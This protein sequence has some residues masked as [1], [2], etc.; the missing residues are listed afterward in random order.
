MR[1]VSVDF[2]SFY[3]SSKEDDACS[4]RTMGGRK[5]CMDPRT[6]PYLISVSDGTETWAGHPRDFNFDSLNGQTLLSHNQG[7]DGLMAKEKILSGVM[8]KFTPAAWHCTANLSVYLSMR[9][10]LLRAAEFLLGVV[11]DKSYRLDADG[12]TGEQLM[13]DP[14]V[15]EKVMAAGR[16]DA[17][18]CW[19]LWAKYSHLWPEHERRLSE[20]TIRQGHRGVQ[21]DVDLL[22]K[23]LHAG[24]SMAINAEQNL[25]WIAEGGKPR[26]TKALAEYCRKAGIPMAPVKKWEGEDAYDEWANNYGAKYPWVKAFS[27]YATINKFIKNCETF[28]ERLDAENVLS[29]DLL[30]FGAH[31]GRWAGGG[32][33]NF[34]A[35]RKTPLFCDHDLFLITD[36]AKQKEIE[37][38][39]SAQEEAKVPLAERTPP[40]F[41]A[42]VLDIRRLIIP[43]PGCKLIS[44]DLS[45]IEPR[46]EAWIVG[47]TK[48]LANMAAGK[49]P[50]QA[51]AEAY[52]DWPAE[53]DLKKSDKDLYAL[54]K[55]RILG[56]GFQCGWKKFITVAM[57]MAQLD[58]TKND[59][60][61]IQKLD[62]DGNPMFKLDGNPMMESG[63]GFTSKK[64]VKE[65]RES[66]PLIASNDETNPGI[67]RRL[68][69]L[70]RA[71]AGGDFKMTLPSGRDLRYPEVKRLMRMKQDEETGKMQR[72]WETTA[73][74]FDPKRNGV[75]RK[76]FYGGILTE[77]LVQ[78]T[79]RDI[80][81]E[82]LLALDAT[83]G[84]EVLF[85]VHDE[86]VCEVAEH[87]T[88]HDV[89]TIMG[90]TPEW[91]AGCPIAAEANE[92]PFYTK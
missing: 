20:L 26:S 50:Y 10:D 55:A 77:N 16:S 23:F 27:D 12:K 61:E 8:P 33:I 40:D 74:V 92:L 88:K 28:K 81:A 17:L 36:S 65:Y 43:R 11:V 38:H 29:F 46:V 59:P 83:P 34:Q 64:T 89:E 37:K 7:F 58:I 48:M 1:F 6:D 44:S 25:P 54:A 68:D 4:I 2:E 63:Y 35:F 52:M 31:T 71:S 91:I 70:L 18:T 86:A 22:K 32:G 75:V 5:Y 78:A 56:L 3:E 24:Q 57:N 87:V 76:P 9:R 67:W 73:L 90:K 51:H 42:H 14:A 66:N 53:K 15:W 13:A 49:S 45:Q 41:V 72:K 85:S 47:D 69:D 80:F 19:Q 21:I 39:Y 60:K 79:A 82:H 84:I 30:Y 62:E